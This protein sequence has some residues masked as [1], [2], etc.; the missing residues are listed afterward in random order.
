MSSITATPPAR[1]AAPKPATVRN[2]DSTN[3]KHVEPEMKPAKPVAG[4]QSVS[5]TPTHAAKG[6]KVDNLA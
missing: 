4:I 1:V 2:P 6:N 3:A 5:P